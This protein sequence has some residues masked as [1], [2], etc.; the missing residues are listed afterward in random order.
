MASGGYAA[1]LLLDT[2][3]LVGRMDLRASEETL[4][5]WMAAAALVRPASG[6]GQ[7][8]VVADAA[9]PPVQAL[10]R[11]DPVWH[12]ARELE[13]RIATGLPPAMRI[14]TLTGTAPALAD[15]MGR[16]ELPARAA[17]LGPTPH[18]AGLRTLIQVPRAAGLTLAAALRRAAGERSARKESDP[19][20]VR[21]DPQVIE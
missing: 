8:V 13:D 21:I 10:V 11:W 15:F 14:A 4:R 2:W 12:A 3:A 7:V 17:V 5:R 19:V 18:E 6:G 20:N 1:A 16:L 9:L